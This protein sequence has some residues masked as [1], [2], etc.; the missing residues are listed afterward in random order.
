MRKRWS[1]ILG[2]R[3]DAHGREL[4]D[5]AAALVPLLA[6]NAERADA[7]RRIPEV[8]LAALREAGLLR[9]CV[10]RAVGGH[11][12]G[13]GTL[14][15]VCAELGRGCASTAWV[16]ALFG[17]GSVLAGMFGDTVR[18]EIWG[19]SPDATLCG[20]IGVPL[21]ARRVPGGY[22][23]DGR[24]GWI[25]GIRHSNWVG[26]DVLGER[27]EEGAAQRAMAFMPT[28]AVT[29]EDTWDMTGMRGTGSDTAVAEDL[30]V[31]EDRMLWFADAAAGAYHRGGDH[32]MA[33]RLPFP[34]LAMVSF[35]APVLGLGV[36]VYEHTVGTLTAG[37]P[38]VSG[39]RLHALARDT[40]GVQANV[41]D[42]AALIDSAMLRMAWA[43]GELDRA[44]LAGEILPELAGARVRV[45]FAHAARSIRQ[46]ADMLLDVGGAS[47]FAR[48]SPTQRMWRDLGTAT[49]HPAFVT[50][51]NR[52]RYGQLLLTQ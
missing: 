29:V 27:V 46:A 22:V 36:A 13:V 42:A 48:S 18:E 41:A 33:T 49:R 1:D 19:D 7:E 20:A 35:I 45:D 14:L 11:G 4:V 44:A 40:P 8:N 6:A 2:E 12:A 52:E 51:I 16:T 31:P 32:E 39:S 30:F 10:P 24:W 26:L 28:T 50:E 23:L 17:S 37:R 34:V 25:S 47:G 5:S 9:L 21:P 43:T 3:L 15:A 38:V